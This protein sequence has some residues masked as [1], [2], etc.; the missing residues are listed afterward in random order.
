MKLA[1]AKTEYSPRRR[2]VRISHDA[3]R[4][5]QKRYFLMAMELMISSSFSVLIS[6]AVPWQ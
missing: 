4:D 5:V 3:P 2:R 1:G 6:A